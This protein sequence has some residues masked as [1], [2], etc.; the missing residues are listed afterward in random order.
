[1][2]E[3]RLFDVKSLMLASPSRAEGLE[4]RFEVR[5]ADLE[6]QESVYHLNARCNCRLA[7]RCGA[8]WRK[9]AA[10]PAG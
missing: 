5:S 6:L 2:R 9:S 1:M 7:I 3:P 8:D 4:G 10:F